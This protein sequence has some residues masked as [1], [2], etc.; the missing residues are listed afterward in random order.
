MY[1]ACTDIGDYESITWMN[2]IN[3]FNNRYY[4]NTDSKS[5]MCLVTSKATPSVQD[6]ACRK[7]PIPR[8]N[9][10]MTDPFFLDR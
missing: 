3:V 5:R 4:Y 8:Q 1:I 2:Y 10:L 6:I 7:I 9:K